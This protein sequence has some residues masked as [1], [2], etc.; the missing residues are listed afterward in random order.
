MNKKNVSLKK[1]GF[2]LAKT[3]MAIGCFLSVQPALSQDTL[4]IKDLDQTVITGTR[5]EKTINDVGRS[6]S[7][8]SN[9]DIENS[10]YSNVSD[11]LSKQEGIYIVG[12]GQNPGALQSIFLRGANSEHTIILIDGVRITDP[13]STNNAINLAELSLANI[14]RIEIVRGSH[15]TLYGS[16]AIGGVINIITKKAKQSGL[17]GGVQITGGN[18]GK[19]TY[20]ISESVYLNYATKN[21]IYVSG[22]IFN[23]NVNGLDA[24]VDTVTNPNTYKNRDNDGFD[25]MDFIGKIGY[26]KNKWDVFG[27]YKITSQNLDIDDGAY[28]D[29]DNYTIDFN[30]NI[31]SYQA[32]Y[33]INDKLNIKIIGGFTDMQRTAIDDS[34]IVDVF[35]NYDHSYSESNYSGTVLN[36]ELQI[37]YR[38]NNLLFTVGA[39]NY[40][41][42]MTSNL[43]YTNTAWAYVSESNL[44][45]LNIQSS[46]NSVYLHVDLDGELISEKLNK[47]NLALGTR[48]NNHSTYGDYLTYEINPS[49][50]IG[51]SSFVYGSF[52]TGFNSPALYRLYSPNQDAISNV[53]RGNIGLVPETSAS[54]EIGLKQQIGKKTNFTLSV[55]QT[56]VDNLIEYVYLWDKAIGIDTLGNDWARNDYRGDSYLNIGSQINQGF[57]FGISTFLSEK[58]TLTANVSLVSGRLSYQPDNSL[59]TNDYHVQLF[60][61]GDFITEAIEKQGLVRRSNTA[62]LRLTYLPISKLTLSTDVRYAGVRSDIYY[63]SNLGPYGALAQ[64]SVRDYTLIDFTAKYNVLKNLVAIFN[65]SNILNTQYQEINGYTT[66]GRGY[67]LKI[68]Y[69]I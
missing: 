1:L 21:G 6:V 10:V 27:S 31:F 30:R 44:D 67:Y 29:D 61:T 37:D 47:F 16:S 5:T 40:K 2:T 9:E 57:E 22:E 7:V 13:S 52:S 56:N 26:K 49:Y 11:L 28:K 45:A 38:L 17:Q 50:K 53:T 20:D 4:R 18:F 68:K 12:N 15:S 63:N 8:I 34:S 14:E 48:F 3:T 65:V 66:R 55:F 59:Y 25:K 36:S 33:Q 41:E 46:T 64:T 42:T 69:S 24:T 51:K 62:N 35:G 43:Y 39:G 54:Y 19:S 60:A 58:L 23:T 32:K